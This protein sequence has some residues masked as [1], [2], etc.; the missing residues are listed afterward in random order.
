MNSHLTFLGIKKR[1]RDVDYCVDTHVRRYSLLDVSTRV[2][3]TYL[4]SKSTLRHHT[5][6]LFL[7]KSLFKASKRRTIHTQE[8]LGLCSLGLNGKG[9]NRGQGNKEN[10][11]L[12][13]LR[14]SYTDHK[15]L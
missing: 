12:V 11:T 9:L 3:Q 14:G 6:T 2:V 7:M 15:L 5:V 4:N 10:T 13:E 1:G 8:S